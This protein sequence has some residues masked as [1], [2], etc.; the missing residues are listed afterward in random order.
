M[1]KNSAVVNYFVAVLLMHAS[2]YRN[3]HYIFII[4]RVYTKLCPSQIEITQ[5]WRYN[6][7]SKDCE[8]QN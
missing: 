2:H 1:N 8:K 6:T 3:V 5:N 4:T 7:T